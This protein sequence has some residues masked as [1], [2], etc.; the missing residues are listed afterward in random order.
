MSRIRVSRTIDAPPARVWAAVEDISTHVRWM[1]DAESITFTS[2]R[3][4]GEGTRFDCLTRV[5]PFALI[6]SMEITRWDE[7]KA[8]GVIHSGLVTGVGEFTLKAKG[9][10]K[11]K[12]T[13]FT[14]R[15]KLRFP[16]WMG[17]PLGALAA[18][19]VMILIW[20]RSL[21]RLADLVESGALG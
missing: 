12:R 10:G 8:M 4:R 13:K 3:T 17:G 20:R 1:G 15:E 18:K 21:R 5:G 19:P 6:D 16:F 7:G 14:W 9:R 11:S 2:D